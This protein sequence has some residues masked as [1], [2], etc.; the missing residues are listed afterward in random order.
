MAELTSRPPFTDQVD[1]LPRQAGLERAGKERA[2]S[3]G[4]IEIQQALQIYRQAIERHPNDWRLHLSLGKF[5]EALGKPSEAAGQF[6][7]AVKMFPRFQPL[8]LMLGKALVQARQTDAGLAQ[9]AEALRIDPKNP[10]AQQ[11][12]AWARSL[13]DGQ[14][15]N[16]LP[17]EFGH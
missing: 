3:F 7:F 10:A 12:M 15:T 1:H 17:G 6:Q 4:E 2:A 14:R 9:F 13:K 8:R 16:S 5:Y 11:G